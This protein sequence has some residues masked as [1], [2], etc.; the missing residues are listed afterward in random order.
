[1]ENKLGFKE[2]QYGNFP[3]SPVVEISPSN[4]GGKSSVPNWRDEI[5]HASQLKNKNIKEQNQ[6]PYC[7]KFIKRLWK[8]ELKELNKYS[9]QA[10]VNMLKF[11]SIIYF[12][13][14]QPLWSDFKNLLS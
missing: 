2:N 8:K 9:V 7:N 1:M 14:L 6:K 4:E 3:G 10:T 12:E 11:N 13:M 5:P